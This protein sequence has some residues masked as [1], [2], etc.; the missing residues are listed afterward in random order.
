[1]TYLNCP[2]CRLTIYS[3]ARQTGARKCP[4]CKTEMGR[5]SRLFRSALPTRFKRFERAGAT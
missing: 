3:S 5:A 2:S 4:R 1:M